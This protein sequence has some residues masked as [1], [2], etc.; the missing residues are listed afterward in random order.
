MACEARW[1]R[2]RRREAFAVFV[3]FD[4]SASG[5]PR[6]ES[7]V[8]L[9]RGANHVDRRLVVPPHRDGGQSQYVR[10]P[11][12]KHTGAGLAAVMESAVRRLRAPITVQALARQANMSERTF[13]R[14]FHDETGTTPH[15]WLTQQRLVA[16]QRSL[17][18]TRDSIDEVAEA[19][20]FDTA[21][22]L[23][24][25]FRRVFGTTPTAYRN[26]FALSKPGS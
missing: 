5:S 9:A 26:R 6:N 20:G 8:K 21:E 3:P 14:R 12:R 24:H 23:R 25:H 18:T 1:N 2:V 22:T 4:S 17:E 19:A 11:I 13:A 7:G 10:T 15:Q 16:A